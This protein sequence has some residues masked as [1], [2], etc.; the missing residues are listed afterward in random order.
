MKIHYR[1]I[2]TKEMAICYNCYIIIFIKKVPVT[3]INQ[4]EIP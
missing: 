4:N 1:K 2:P 3:E